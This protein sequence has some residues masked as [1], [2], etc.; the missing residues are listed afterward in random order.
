M[1][2]HPSIP[3]PRKD[4]AGFRLTPEEW[5]AKGHQIKQTDPARSARYYRLAEMIKN[6][7]AIAT[8]RTH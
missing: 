4:N 8:G 3:P 5:Q 6:K 1:S 2:T 7:I